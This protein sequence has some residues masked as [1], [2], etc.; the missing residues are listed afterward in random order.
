MYIEDFLK[1]LCFNA[2]C[3]D[4]KRQIILACNGNPKF[5]FFQCHRHIFALLQMCAVK[6]IYN[7]EDCCELGNNQV[8]LAVQTNTS[9]QLIII[10]KGLV[11]YLTVYAMISCSR[12]ES[13]M[14]SV[15]IMIL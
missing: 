6:C 4:L 12:L 10:D 1:E 8:F 9:G 15:A 2:E 13:P 3:S 7:T 5:V 11:L 14:I